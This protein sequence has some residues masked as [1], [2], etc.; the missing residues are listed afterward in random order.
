M[1]LAKLSAG[2]NWKNTV[3]KNDFFQ[4]NYKWRKDWESGDEKENE[5]EGGKGK[6]KGE[7][8][9]LGEWTK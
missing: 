9:D 3:W 7:R 8:E 6:G 2:W 1:E 4:R 5:T